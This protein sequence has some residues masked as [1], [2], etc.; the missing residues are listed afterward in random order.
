MAIFIA[1]V[2]SLTVWTST[3]PTLATEAVGTG[4]A[5]TMKAVAQDA[6]NK[7]AEVIHFMIR[8]PCDKVNES[9]PH[10]L[11]IV[12]SIFFNTLHFF[13]ILFSI[14]ATNIGLSGSRY[15]YTSGVQK[16]T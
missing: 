2:F 3:P 12:C 5:A 7:A 10:A 11:L 15:E 13:L 1:S 16:V 14:K 4:E 9:I 8:R 6:K